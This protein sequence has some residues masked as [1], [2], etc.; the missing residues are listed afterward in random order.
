MGEREIEK[1]L[2]RKSYLREEES[3]ADVQEIE[4]EKNQNIYLSTI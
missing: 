4:M 3:F 2:S 1:W